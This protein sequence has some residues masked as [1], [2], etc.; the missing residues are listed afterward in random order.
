MRN[1]VAV[2]LLLGLG[3]S[4]STPPA[5]VPKVI[6]HRTGGTTFQLLP[7]EGQLEHC[8]AY[9]VSQRGTLRLLTMSR[10]N[11]SYHC[12]PGKPVGNH[13]YRVPLNE[14]PVKVIVLFSS[15]EL[16]AGSVSQQLLELP[17]PRALK[18]MELR[19]PG[20]A[21]VETLDFTPEEDVAPT[22]GTALG[23]GGGSAG[24]GGADGG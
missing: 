24:P 4:P 1:A 11:E 15:T 5:P 22:E 2:A 14:G 9:T 20:S 13:V 21:N 23:A 12:P 7:A 6:L 3:C 16:N 10:K 17:N 8:L 19:L 18:T